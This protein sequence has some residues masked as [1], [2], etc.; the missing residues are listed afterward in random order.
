MPNA[1]VAAAASGL[2]N[3]RSILAGAAAALAVPTAAV[4]TASPLDELIADYRLACEEE[5]AL[6]AE[7]GR[8]DDSTEIPQIAVRY[9]KRRRQDP[10]TGEVS[11][12]PWIFATES[13]I[14]QH[15]DTLRDSWHVRH[16]PE[17]VPEV[18]ARRA[19]ALADYHAQKLAQDEALRAS[20]LAAAAL[21]ADQALFRMLGIRREIFAYRPATLSEVATK[22][23]FL[24]GLLREGIDLRGDLEAIF[25]PNEKGVMN[26]P[27]C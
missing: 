18:E 27:S 3:R 12:G 10:A 9:G 22:N 4:A 20:G 14:N 8:I 13:Q 6:F 1:R 11:F 26:T 21:L 16:Q 2:P 24:L 17:F 19:T 15:F 25:A 5:E 7:F 23:A